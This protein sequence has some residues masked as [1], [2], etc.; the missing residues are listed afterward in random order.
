MHDMNKYTAGAIS[1]MYDHGFLRRIAYGE[2]EILRMIYFA[3]RDHNWNTIPHRIENEQIVNQKNGFQIQF[4]C[5]HS[6]DG[7]DVMAWTANIEGLPDGTLVYEITGKALADFNKNRAGFCVLHPLSVT[8]QLCTITHPDLST[9]KRVFPSAVAA[10]NPFKNIISMAWETAGQAYTLSFEGEVFETEDQRNWSD[11]SFKTFCTTLDKPFPVLLKKGEVVYQRI[12]FK[13]SSVLATVKAG[14]DYISLRDTGV[15]SIVPFMGVSASTEI[16]RLSPQGEILL[17]GLQLNHYRIDLYPGNANWVTLFSRQYE[18]AFALGLGLEVAL[19]LT[20]NFKEETEAFIILCQQNKVKVKKLLLLSHN[21]LVTGQR[22]IDHAPVI[23]QTLPKVSLGAGT[24]Y[25]FNEINKNQFN[26]KGLDFIS[27][28]IDPQEHATDDLTVLENTESMSHLVNSARLIYGDS[29]RIHISPV[30]LRKRFNPYATNPADHFIEETK[31]ADPRQKEAFAAVWGFGSVCSLA[32]G[33]AE[34]VTFFQTMGNQGI[35]SA[36]AD[37]YPVYQMLKSFA[38]FQGKQANIMESSDP[39][40]VQG[41]LLDTK[42]LGLVNMTGDQT[43]I[44]INN[45]IHHLGPHEIK[46]EPLPRP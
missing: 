32:K 7:V 31:K 36:D 16:D 30:T 21:G 20:E 17:R 1:V 40:R 28:S 33:G 39:L 25:N 41:I 27:F 5:F 34:S 15:K 38:V 44:H 12:T 18:N 19:H 10:E 3:L 2:T 29:I 23:K 35:I 42:V 46:F 11:A 14:P 24:D 8:G 13:P 4:D 6:R 26:A 37:P 22:I 9:T 43:E 45:N